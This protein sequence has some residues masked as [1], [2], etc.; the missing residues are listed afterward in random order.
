MKG[1]FLHLSFFTYYITEN[2]EKLCLPSGHWYVK[3]GSM[4]EWTNFTTCIKVNNLVVQEY[5]HIG[6]YA[7]SAMALLPAIVIFFSFK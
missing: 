2:A 5:A 6:M 7:I 3:P 1:F 4:V